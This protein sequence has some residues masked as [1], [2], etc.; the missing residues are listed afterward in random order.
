VTEG[1][2]RMEDLRSFPCPARQPPVEEAGS[3][4]SRRLPNRVAVCGVSLIG[5][6]CPYQSGNGAKGPRA[7]SGAGQPGQRRPASG[8]GQ[9]LPTSSGPLLRIP[10]VV[11]RSCR[12]LEVGLPGFA[13]SLT[14]APHPLLLD[15]RSGGAGVE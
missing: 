13:S 12:Y 5:T 6:P 15:L 7:A 1:F 3:F 9:G 11:V 8:G 10:W 2:G 14:W 4:A